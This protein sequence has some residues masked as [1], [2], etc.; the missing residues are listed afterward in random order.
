MRTPWVPP[1]A[2]PLV[3]VAVRPPSL[4]RVS[5]AGGSVSPQAFP[6]VR[7]RLGGFLPLPVGGAG[8]AKGGALLPPATPLGIFGNVR[9]VG[10]FGC[11]AA[12]WS[13]SVWGWSFSR[14]PS[15]RSPPSS[16]ARRR[17]PSSPSSGRVSRLTA[18]RCS[19]V[20]N[21]SAVAPFASGRGA[22][23]SSSRGKRAASIGQPSES[24]PPNSRRQN[25]GRA[26]SAAAAGG[27]WVSSRVIRSACCCQR[28][29]SALRS[30]IWLS[31]WRR[32]L[33]RSSR[34]FSNICTKDAGCSVCCSGVS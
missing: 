6:C 9:G 4:R 28:S 17:G 16:P 34:S 8:S 26:V 24:Y 22:C 12:G 23:Q 29:R 30:S 19:P 21:P 13:C 15:G 5:L 25:E 14:S 32:S 2:L 10:F 18:G 7:F 1:P 27:W 33:S 3:V 11:G 31:S 20:G